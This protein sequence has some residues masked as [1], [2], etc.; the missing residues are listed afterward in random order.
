MTSGTGLLRLPGCHAGAVDGGGQS[1]DHGVT[2]C[3]SEDFTLSQTKPDR[4]RKVTLLH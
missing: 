4:Y 3:Q 1:E 2:F